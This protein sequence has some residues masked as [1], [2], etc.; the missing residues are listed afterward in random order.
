M[1]A[2]FRALPAALLSLASLTLI[3]LGLTQEVVAVP[4]PP[5]ETPQA[6]QSTYVL[7]DG[8]LNTGTPN[9]QGFLYLTSPFLGALATQVFSSGVT[10]LDTTP[11]RSDYAGYFADIAQYPPLDRQPGYQVLFT[12]QVVTESHASNN[13]AG[14]SAI[15]LS[16][17]QQ[18]IELGFWTNE[19]WAQEG[20]L[21]PTLFTHAEGAAFD[22]TADLI[23][24]R[25]VISG[26]T[27]NLSANGS[28]VL[29][30]GL[31]VYTAA[32]TQFPINPYTLP[33]LIFL[34]DDT[35]SAQATIRLSEVS[36]ID[37]PSYGLYLP[38][39]MK[40]TVIADILQLLSGHEI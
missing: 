9:T 6:A 3:T 1:Q 11:R 18:G 5:V 4:A 36:V 23:N 21:S 32:M 26:S 10:T 34:G 31:R 22:T 17:D 16:D 2:L 39:I 40:S 25:L 38:L 27:Y 33:N 13:R 29:S 8:A 35:S 15:V 7:Y 20:G 28:T 37:G 14:F 12:A 30:G 24:Y 19:I